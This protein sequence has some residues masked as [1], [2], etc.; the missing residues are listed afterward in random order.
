[1]CSAGTPEQDGLLEGQSR[2]NGLR[3]PDDV[4]RRLR[5]GR[6]P[7]I[8]DGERLAVTLQPPAVGGGDVLEP[9]AI[10]RN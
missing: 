5:L 6:H 3:P 4:G 8:G 1:M 9:V 10:G 2:E 7:R